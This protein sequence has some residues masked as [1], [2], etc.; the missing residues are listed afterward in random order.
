MTLPIHGSDP[1]S[2]RWS[3]PVE[4]VRTRPANAGGGQP[5]LPP[6]PPVPRSEALAPPAP[7]SSGELRQL[8]R[9]QAPP[10]LE[11]PGRLERGRLHLE[12]GWFHTAQGIEALAERLVAHEVV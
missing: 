12:Q 6:M 11:D 9:T 4:P 5:P 2:L 10:A 8:A 3:Q 7:A 1:S